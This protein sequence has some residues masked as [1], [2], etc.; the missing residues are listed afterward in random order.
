M[1][2]V[3]IRQA[4]PNDDAVIREII[5][6]AFSASELGHNGEADLVQQLCERCAEAI[7]LVA[8]VDGCPVGHVLFTPVIIDANP[9]HLGMGLAPLSVL[10]RFQ[11]QGV[12]SELT[13]RGLEIVRQ[14]QIPFVVVLGHPDYYRRFGFEPAS[15]YSVRARFDLPEE[16]FMIKI[17]ADGINVAGVAHYLPEF[18]P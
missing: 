10:P 14:E 5:T 3:K 2:I 16:L 4:Q 11:R 18:G 13:R 9:R 7:S 1:Q 12:G 6:A 17:L 8:E 15:T